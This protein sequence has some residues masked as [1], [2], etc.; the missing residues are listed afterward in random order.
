MSPRPAPEGHPPPW[1]VL[2]DTNVLLDVLLRREG[3]VEASARLWDAADRGRLRGVIAATAVTTV[4]Y[5]V[6]RAYDDA[7]ARADIQAVLETFEVA[8]VGRVELAGALARGFAD[9]EDGVVHEAARAARCDGIVT[10]NGRDFGAATLPVYAPD[11]L[12]AALDQS[13]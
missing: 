11:E 8:A 12:L 9:L 5:L 1:R 2:F 6:S 10:R 13:E 7:R 3:R 4:G